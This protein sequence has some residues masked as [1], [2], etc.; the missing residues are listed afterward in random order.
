[1]PVT[2]DLTKLVDKA[3]QD[4]TLTEIVDAPVSALAG[5]SDGDAKLLKDAFNIT[6]VGDLGRNPYFRTANAL[7]ALAGGK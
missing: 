7:V 2:A 1:M 6:T 3:Y 5:V 4:K